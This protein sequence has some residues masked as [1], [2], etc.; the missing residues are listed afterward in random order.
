MRPPAASVSA[1]AAAM[2]DFPVPPLAGHKVQA[3]L[4][5]GRDGQPTG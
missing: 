5:T 3:G 4:R 2:V 1:S